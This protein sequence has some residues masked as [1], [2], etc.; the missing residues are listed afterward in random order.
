MSAARTW[1]PLLC[2]CRGWGPVCTYCTEY[3]REDA[4]RRAAASTEE[5]PGVPACPLYVTSHAPG[6]P[7]CVDDAAQP[8][9]V[10]RG[11]ITYGQAYD[12]A[13]DAA[14]VAGKDGAA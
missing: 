12:E 5:C 8:C 4:A 10:A 11:E 14:I 9:R 2:E 1:S 13:C 6:L 3:L 7:G